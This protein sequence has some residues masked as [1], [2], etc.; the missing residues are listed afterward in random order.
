VANSITY[1]AKLRASRIAAFLNEAPPEHRE[2]SQAKADA[3]Y[4]IRALGEASDENLRLKRQ[5]AA[6]RTDRKASRK[7]AFCRAH[8]AATTPEELAEQILDSASAHPEGV[9]VYRVGGQVKWRPATGDVP[10]GADVIGKFT[11]GADYR[12]V[13]DNVAEAA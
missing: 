6:L 9:I 11:E 7:A 1:D 8:K 5:I 12:V 10:P 13:L 4:I 3:L 2:A